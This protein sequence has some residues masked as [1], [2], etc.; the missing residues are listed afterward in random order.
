MSHRKV[1]K[2][3]EEALFAKWDEDRSQQGSS[4]SEPEASGARPSDLEGS[5]VEGTIEGVA[6]TQT[7]ELG[8]FIPK[9]RV[10]GRS[11]WS[12]LCQVVLER[13]Y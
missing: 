5:S 2:T 10:L 6:L 7:E 1:F 8:I 9:R 11:W 4:A 13:G 12:A 3:K